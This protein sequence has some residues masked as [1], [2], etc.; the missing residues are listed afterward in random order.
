MD[1][2]MKSMKSMEMIKAGGSSDASGPTNSSRMY[3]KGGKPSMSAD[4]N[5]RNDRRRGGTT[6]AVGGV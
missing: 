5:P 2:K 4:F 6:W 3:P 1:D